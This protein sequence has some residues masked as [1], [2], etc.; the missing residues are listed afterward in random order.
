MMT[1]H[2]VGKLT[3]VSIRTLQYYDRIGLLH[4]AAYT[5]AGYR[6]YDEAALERL[7]QILLF[8]ELEF[9]LKEIASILQSPDFDR[10]RALDQ[11]IRLLTLRREHLDN[12][13]RFARELKQI[14]GKNMDFSAFDTKKMEAYAAEAKR[15]WGHT[16][17]Y[18]EYAAK[19]KDRTKESEKALAAGMMQSIHGEYRQSRRRG[20]RSI[21]RTRDLCPM[22][23]VFMRPLSGGNSSQTYPAGVHTALPAA[24]RRSSSRDR[25]ACGRYRDTAPRPAPAHPRAAPE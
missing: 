1:V 16:D 8:R 23:I 24:G 7:Q 20:D 13:I 17:A 9:S 4:P 14:G 3:G 21:C 10:E 19:S 11:Q 12:L 5:D 22:R 25:G 15:Q 2:E 6:L 18:R